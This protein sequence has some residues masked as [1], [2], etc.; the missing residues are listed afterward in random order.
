MNAATAWLP[1]DGGPIYAETPKVLLESQFLIEPWNALSSLLIIAPAIYF[2]FHL[3][4]KYRSNWFL[5]LCIPLLI[6]GGTGS[7][8]FHAFRSSPYLLDLDVWPTA[9]LFLAVSTYF[10]AKV[11][12]SWWAALGIMAL[13][14]A[15]TFAIFSY[16]PPL[17]RM[18]SAYFL[19]GLA[20]FAPVVMVLV[21]TRFQGAKFIFGGLIA[22]ALALTCRLIDL[23]TTALLPMGTHFLWH[24][25]TG[26]GG[27]LIAEYLL[28]MEAQKKAE[29]FIT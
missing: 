8:L 13:F 16:F 11:L 19:R 29:E 23:E 9:L 17:L 2:L 27:F 28:Q 6:L 5:V 18:N 10:W 1:T 25:F 14:F 15:A 3:R 7:T 20:F 21:K 22:F 24:A 12:K 4:G 26:L